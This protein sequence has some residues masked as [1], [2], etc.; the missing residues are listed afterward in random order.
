M[1]LPDRCSRNIVS[2]ECRGKLKDYATWRL[3]GNGPVGPRREVY[4]DAEQVNS[5]MTSSQPL[6]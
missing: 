3:F 6:S 4:G 2:Y 5:T 1:V